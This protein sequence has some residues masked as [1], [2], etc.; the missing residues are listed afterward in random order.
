M[1]EPSLQDAFAPETRCF[2]CGPA[3]DKGLRIKSFVEGDEVVSRWLP[4]K[5]HEAFDGFLNG[6][7][8]G[9]LFDCHLNWAASHH[10]MV[11]NGLDRVPPTVTADYHVVF[12]KPTP[13]DQPVTLRARVVDST[14]R[15]ATVE[16]VMEAPGGVTATCRGTFV[17][18]AEGHPAWGR[19]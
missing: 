3:N 5:H 9:A 12:K 16:G 17:A 1:D 7:I 13:S 18:I 6:G 2:G 8:I 10:L 4:E 14:A 19:W 11:R 15:R